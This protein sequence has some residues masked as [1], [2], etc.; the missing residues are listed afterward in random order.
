MMPWI[1]LHP[2]RR[3]PAKRI[4]RRASVEPLVQRNQARQAGAPSDLTRKVFDSSLSGFG[5]RLLHGCI[6]LVASASIVRRMTPAM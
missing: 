6:G 3:R 1:S 5:K 2:T 4:A